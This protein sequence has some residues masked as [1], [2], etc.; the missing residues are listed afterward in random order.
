MQLLI[1][2]KPSTLFLE[3]WTNSPTYIPIPSPVT[4]AHP[5]QEVVR[6][7]KM[8]PIS[9]TEKDASCFQNTIEDIKSRDGKGL[10][11]PILCLL[12]LLL[13]AK[14][15]WTEESLT[16]KQRA[17]GTKAPFTLEPPW[18]EELWEGGGLG[19][20]AAGRT[21]KCASSPAEATS[22]ATPNPGMGHVCEPVLE[23]QLFLPDR[24]RM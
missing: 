21:A 17:M 19:L 11:G 15:Q 6:L 23:T 24:C 20:H 12:L 1:I 22:S 10:W 9:V 4:F 2:T 16:G 3:F 8:S 5:L 18:R 7:P 14:R 13:V